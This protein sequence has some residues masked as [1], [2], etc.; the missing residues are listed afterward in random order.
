MEDWKVVGGR[1][2]CTRTGANRNVYL[3]THSL[4]NNSAVG[5]ETSVTVGKKPS[6]FEHCRYQ[7]LLL[8]LKKR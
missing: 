7:K 1:I 5:F 6:S 3:L 4:S 8:F 2:E